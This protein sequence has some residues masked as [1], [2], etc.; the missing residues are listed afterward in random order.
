MLSRETETDAVFTTRGVT[1]RVQI[2][3]PFWDRLS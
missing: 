3:E 2:T 1:T